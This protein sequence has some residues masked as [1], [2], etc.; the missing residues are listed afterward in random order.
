MH[1][2]SGKK[3]IGKGHK[4]RSFMPYNSGIFSRVRRPT[5]S[6]IAFLI[7]NS[8]DGRAPRPSVMRGGALG[9]SKQVPRGPVLSHSNQRPTCFD[10]NAMAGPRQK[11]VSS[12]VRPTVEPSKKP[13]DKKEISQSIRTPR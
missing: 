13:M 11:P 4:Y 10:M 9:V 12:V 1:K 6:D 2:I 5:G 7:E 8:Y 3:S